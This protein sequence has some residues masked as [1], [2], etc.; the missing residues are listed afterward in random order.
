MSDSVQSAMFENLKSI[1]GSIVD[2]RAEVVELRRTQNRR[3]EAMELVMRNQRR[4]MAGMLVVMKAAAGVF[5]EPVSNLETRVTV[6][7]Q[8]RRS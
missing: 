5:E 1:Q 3:M 7:E 4:D 2:L 8:D 6:L